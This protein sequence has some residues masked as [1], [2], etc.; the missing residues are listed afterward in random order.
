MAGEG[1]AKASA[2]PFVRSPGSLAISRTLLDA[3]RDEGSIKFARI[4]SRAQ[5]RHAWR[6]RNTTVPAPTA[7]NK[8][9]LIL[10]PD[11]I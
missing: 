2:M 11:W 6:R 8:V 3:G 9:W 7:S 1:A 5:A 4:T 10:P